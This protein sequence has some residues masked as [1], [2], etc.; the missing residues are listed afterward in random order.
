M[1][2][3]MYAGAL[4]VLA[5]AAAACILSPL[6]LYDGEMC[7]L[8]TTAMCEMAAHRAR[9]QRDDEC[10]LAAGVRT[11]ALHPVN[12]AESVRALRQQGYATVAQALAQPLATRLRQELVALARARPGFYS[13]RGCIGALSVCSRRYD[14]PLLLDDVPALPEALAEVGAALGPILA[15]LVG[16]SGE[17]VELSAML[18]CRGSP[19]QRLHPDLTAGGPRRLYSVFVALQDVSAELGATRVVPATHLAAR[20]P[21]KLGMLDDDDD[22]LDSLEV[23]A[24]LPTGAALIYDA[25]TV[26]RAGANNLGGRA[27]LMLS[28]QH[29]GPPLEGSTY[30]LHSN[31]TRDGIGTGRFTVGDLMR[32]FVGGGSGVAA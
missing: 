20:N 3:S 14:V 25:R 32:N 12:A 27:M 2:A 1:A 15:D 5:L 6:N 10:A 28:V 7:L 31:L 23:P 24:A 30:S 8:P 4:V 18:T 29:A 26:H 16:E 17:L 11:A 22:E 19:A 9:A 21:I 13:R